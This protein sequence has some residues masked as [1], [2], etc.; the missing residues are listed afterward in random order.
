MDA[1]QYAKENY[2]GFAGEGWAYGPFFEAGL[3]KEDIAEIVHEYSSSPEGYGSEDVMMVFKTPDGRFGFFEAWCDTTGWDCQ[4][5]AS[6]VVYAET[7]TE[8]IF[9]MTAD[10]RRIFG[11]EPTPD[12]GV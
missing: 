6:D 2:F 4:A 7:L 12:C 3:K 1:E 5:G 9:E 8:L 10:A 11:Y